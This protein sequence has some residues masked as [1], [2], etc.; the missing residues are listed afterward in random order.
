MAMS[1]CKLA[2]QSRYCWRWCDGGTATR[3]DE[4]RR[5]RVCRRH[6]LIAI[7]YHRDGCNKLPTACILFIGV[8]GYPHRPASANGQPHMR[9]GRLA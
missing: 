5:R 6:A 3:A 1:R 8:A 2:S 4:V 9:S 7:E